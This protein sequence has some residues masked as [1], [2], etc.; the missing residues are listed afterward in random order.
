MFYEH[1]G[2]PTNLLPCWTNGKWISVAGYGD[3]VLH[4]DPWLIDWTCRT[5][6][7]IWLWEYL[8]FGFIEEEKNELPTI[9]H[10]PD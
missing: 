4:G 2:R 6:N 1:Y 7:N 5:W 3:I 8:N 10:L 9:T